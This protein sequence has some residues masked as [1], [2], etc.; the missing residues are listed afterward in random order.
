[1]KKKTIKELNIDAQPVVKPID[2]VLLSAEQVGER[3]GR[4]HH[5]IAAARLKAAGAAQIRLGSRTIR[6]R[7][8]DVLRIENEAAT[9]TMSHFRKNIAKE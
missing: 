3:W 9:R 8:S 5:R 6:Y 4:V 1:L 7:L 2:D